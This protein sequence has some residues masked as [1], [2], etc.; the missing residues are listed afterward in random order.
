MKL[1]SVKTGSLVTTFEADSRRQAVRLAKRIQL[2]SDGQ[3]FT[4]RQAGRLS[5]SDVKE[6][7]FGL[8]WPY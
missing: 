4:C 2:V 1:Y 8:P 6:E 3:V 5:R 7:H